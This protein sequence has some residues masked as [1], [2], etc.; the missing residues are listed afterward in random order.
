MA[1]DLL[2]FLLA[3]LSGV[4]FIAALPHNLKIIPLCPHLVWFA[5]IPY[6]ISIMLADNPREAFLLGY[7]TG[8]VSH[9]ALL[10]WL[11]SFGPI[12]VVL[13]TLTFS[14]TFAVIALFTYYMFERLSPFSW[15]WA[16][17]TAA[18]AVAFFEGIGLWG[19]PWL[20]P[21]YALAKYPVFIQSAD[22]A[23]VWLVIWLVYFTNIALFQIAQSPNAPRLRNRI[24]AV[25][26]IVGAFVLSYG[27]V[28][29]SHNPKGDSINVA[30]IQGGIESDVV[31]TESYNLIARNTYADATERALAE[32]KAD[33]VIWPES[34]IGDN[35][36]PYRVDSLT[37][38]AC[39]GVPSWGRTA[40][41]GT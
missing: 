8:V 22:I 12:P 6:L 36:T 21:A 40:E 25:F 31:W 35:I 3:V 18:T 41:G 30:L 15:W 28:R 39:C 24:T 27:C 23:G 20:Y 7:L 19:F 13:L 11:M 32:A 33:L 4:M 9:G 37:G 38:I 26:V 34:S 10:Y 17:P 29:L 5:F 2:K 16:F 14:L 1:K